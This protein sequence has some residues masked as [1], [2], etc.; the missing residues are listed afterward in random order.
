MAGC[1]IASSDV[2]LA[3]LS[4]RSPQWLVII[5]LNMKILVSQHPK[6]I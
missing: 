5:I 6:K 2:V 4:V 3:D 1:I